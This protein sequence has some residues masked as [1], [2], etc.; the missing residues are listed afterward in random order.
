MADGTTG[1]K[2]FMRGLETG[3]PPELWNVERPDDIIGLYTSFFEAGSDLSLTDSFV[4]N[5]LRLKLHEAQDRVAELN[6]AAARFAR[7]AAD[8]AAD[9]Q[10]RRPILAARWVRL[11]SCLSR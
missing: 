9:R 5:A 4:G 8:A 10:G 2:L 3:Y 6:A 7:I 1:N 11:V